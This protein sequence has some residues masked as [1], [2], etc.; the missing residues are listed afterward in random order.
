[1]WKEGGNV[2]GNGSVGVGSIKGSECER[3][4]NVRENGSVGVGSKGVKVSGLKYQGGEGKEEKKLHG[5]KAVK[6]IEV[7]WEIRKK[8]QF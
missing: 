5:S 8:I 7:N 3:G 1:M 2:R 6:G 4:G